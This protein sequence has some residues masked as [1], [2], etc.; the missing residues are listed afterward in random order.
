MWSYYGAKTNIISLYPKPKYHKIIE[1]FA[2]TARY[3]LKYFENDITIVDKYK[4]VVDIWR[5]LQQCSI[6]DIRSLPHHFKPNQPL[7]DFT[8]DCDGARNLI[9]FLIGF[10]MERPRKTASSKRMTE[11]P[12][13]IN[14]ALNKIEQNLFKIKH[15]NILEGTYDDLENKEATW[16]ID[17]PYQFGG[18]PYPESNKKIDFCDLSNFCKSRIGQVL[19]CE[20]SKATWLNFK[21]FAQQKTRM[22][23]WQKEVIWINSAS[24]YDSVQTNLF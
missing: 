18:H 9:G 12:N 5:Y 23:H 16:F 21:P 22:K 11:R 2:G 8:F 24:E 4:V 14:Q 15:W 6:Q 10:G 3:S 20:N 7:S 1:P 17:P 13:H 19:V